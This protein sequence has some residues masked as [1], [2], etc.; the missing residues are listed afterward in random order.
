MKPRLVIIKSTESSSKYSESVIRV[1]SGLDDLYSNTSLFFPL[2]YS[3]SRPLSSSSHLIPSSWLLIKIYSFRGVLKGSSL[4]RYLFCSL[5]CTHAKEVQLFTRSRNLFRNIRHVSSMP[6]EQV[7]RQDGNLRFLCY[8]SSL[9]SI[10]YW[11]RL[12]F[13]CSHIW[14]K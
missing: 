9:H 6:I 7:H 3:G 12:W 14:C 1:F 5:S 4:V 2:L 10:Y 8:L 13:G 11:L